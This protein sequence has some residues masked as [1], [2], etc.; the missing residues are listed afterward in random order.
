MVFAV[1]SGGYTRSLR[2]SGRQ[3]LRCGLGSGEPAEEGFAAARAAR[4]RGFS[5]QP[6]T[7]AE[8]GVGRYNLSGSLG[9]THV[10]LSTLTR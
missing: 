4:R 2:A 6:A 8:P 9:H 1:R 7:T 10:A 5:R 3:A